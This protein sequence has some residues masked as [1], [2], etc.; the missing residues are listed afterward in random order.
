MRR[1]EQEIMARIICEM[2]DR[3]HNSPVVQSQLNPDTTSVHQLH[4]VS[5]DAALSASDVQT[6]DSHVIGL[7]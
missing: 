4:H 7:C 2:H 3:Q 1:V 6:M 5:S